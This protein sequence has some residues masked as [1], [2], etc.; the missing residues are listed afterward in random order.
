M[1]TTHPL[2]KH[3]LT[4]IIIILSFIVLSLAYMSPVFEGK[5]LV[6]NDIIQAE[7]AAQELKTYREE[8]GKRSLW[9]N[10]MFGGMPAFMISMDY[11]NSLPTHIARFITHILPTPANTLFLYMVGFYVMGLL[12]GFSAWQASVGSLFYALG[13]YNVINIEAGHMSKVFALAF[14]P[15]LIGAIYYAYNH[16]W[17]LGSVLAGVFAS[18]QL[19][20]NHVQIT[21]YVFLTL[22]VFVMYQTVQ[23]ALK[24]ADWK[25][26]ALASASLAVAGL[27]ALG[28]HTS[29]LW[30]AYEY[31]SQTIRGKSE[32]KSNKE[33]TSGAIDKDYAF[34]WSY[35]I[36]ESFTFLI[37]NFYASGS[38]AGKELG[39][40]SH[41]AKALQNIGIDPEQAQNLPYYWGAQ[42]FTSGPAYLGVITCLLAFFGLLASKNNLKWWLVSGSI[43]LIIIAWGNNFLIVND[44]FFQYLP[45][46]NKF[47][48][49][50]MTL[51]LLQ[52][53]VASLALLGVQ[54]LL[55][56]GAD[57]KQMQRHLYI[58]AGTLGGICLIFALL[59]GVF[60]DFSSTGKTK[61]AGENGKTNMV[62]NDQAFLNQLNGSFKDDPAKPKQILQ[63]VRNDRAAMQS[64]DAWRS[65][66]FIAVMTAV[67]W[68]FCA[69]FMTWEYALG[70]IALLGMIDLLGVDRRYLN[71]DSFEDNAQ[72]E[73]KYAL[74]E[75]ESK[76][77][78]DETRYRVANFN[79]NTFNDATTSY[80]FASVGGYHGAKLRRYQDVIDSHLLRDTSAVYDMLNVKY[81][82]IT[83]RDN[84]QRVQKNPLACGNAWFVNS[85]QTV[86]NPDEELKALNIFNPAKKAILDKRFAG[87]VSSIKN[88]Q[89]VVGKIKLTKSLPDE[90]TYETDN[91]EAQL[92]VFSEIY[93]V[94]A[95]KIFWQAYLDGKPVPHLR[96]NYIVRG[97]AVPAG[98]HKITFKFEVP[99]YN[100]GENISFLCSI[101]LFGALFG[102]LYVYYLQQN[103]ATLPA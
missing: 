97:L 87:Q 20:A 40:D 95:G 41:A 45:L 56:K 82:F 22:V 25:R 55:V 100:T 9:A 66:G 37:P 13:S 27:L 26:F 46:F 49:H 53:F 38:R 94:Q 30:T 11:P 92:A 50:T 47:R 2:F 10:N 28:T 29:R 17:W 61:T 64:A 86:D 71:N 93:Y 77:L 43:L 91:A 58:S 57:L 69:G 99:I 85:Y 89:E 98:K 103:K 51:S 12:F 81:F 14:A 84:Q 15:P 1:T 3:L 102:A 63:A 52:L 23:C 16:N 62:S 73:S 36:S 6:Q 24:K 68:A 72:Y 21:Y 19:Y 75:G 88:N 48:A 5:R 74:S 80:N 7:G 78:Q 65:F 67:L 83:T 8:T 42:P 31:T 70:G 35:G 34:A 18:F 59:G 54:A 90:L 4:N 60:Q 33:S 76:V 79:I 96:V 39:K 101:L 32:L 44:L